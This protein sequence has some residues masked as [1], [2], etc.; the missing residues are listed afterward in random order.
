MGSRNPARGITRTHLAL[1]GKRAVDAR[2]P[3][4]WSAVEGAEFAGIPRVRSIDESC[5]AMHWSQAVVLRSWA[6]SP[7]VPWPASL[8]D[9]GCR[10]GLLLIVLCR[11]SAVVA[12][13]RVAV[14]PDVLGAAPAPTAPGGLP[15]GSRGRGGWSVW[16]GQGA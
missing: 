2:V 7:D 11:F 16:C 15:S 14:L 10:R 5:R 1:L 9:S 8:D 13:W 6:T 3:E 4:V 12:G